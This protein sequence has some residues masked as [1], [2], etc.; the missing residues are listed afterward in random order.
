MKIFFTLF[1]LAL[2]LTASAQSFVS[3]P[4]N[5]TT[6]LSKKFLGARISYKEVTNICETTHGIHSYSGYVHLPSYFVPDAGGA[7][8]LPENGN[9]SYFFW[10]FPARNNPESAPTAMYFGGGPGYSGFDGSSAFPCYFNPDSN[11]T[12][13]NKHSWNNHVNM[14]YIDNPVGVGFSY[15]TLANGT[16]DTLTNTFKP[17]YKHNDTLESI[18]DINDL[19]EI[20]LTKT[21]A[22]MHVTDPATTINGTMAAARTIWRFSQVWFN[23]FPEYRTENTKISI[24]GVSY[25]GFYATMFTT[26]FLEQNELIKNGKHEI[27]EATEL[28][29]ATVGIINGVTDIEAM[30]LG[31]LD[32]A[33]NN[34]YGHPIINETS[35]VRLMGLMTDPQKGCFALLRSCRAAQAQNDPQMRG[36]D[37]RVNKACAAASATCLEIGF[38]GV[39]NATIYNPFDISVEKP[40]AFPYEYEAAFFNQQWVQQELGVPL[41]YT[42]GNDAFPDVFFGGTGDP[43]RYDLSHL[44]NILDRGLNVALV[45]GDRDYRCNW[46][47]VENASLHIPFHSAKSFANSGYANIVT[48]SFYNGGLVREH[49]GLSFSRVYQAGHSAGG[50]QPETVSRIFERAMFRK[51]VAT[52]KVELTREE[53]YQSNGKADVRDVKNKLPASID[54]VCYVLQPADTCTKEQKAALVDGTAE[55]KDWVVTSPQGFRGKAGGNHNSN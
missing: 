53:T 49:G 10:Y 7:K 19:K 8:G 4:K 15:T 34:T 45:S 35:Y 6:V 3:P 40:G 17:A 16:L 33:R 27:K 14:L 31:W 41:N 52:G 46:F 43:A 50:F 30:A 12:T 5:I 29:M 1:L 2:G 51:D 25:A 20:D 28:N 22:T 18:T 24:W 39:D 42:R 36:I 11:S 44:G 38:T 26:Y 37:A 47:S 13:L 48:N 21:P 54:S 9:A 55:T 23:E 32:Y